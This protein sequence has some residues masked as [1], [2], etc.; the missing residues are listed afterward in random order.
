MRRGGNGETGAAGGTGG[1]A[2]CGSGTISLDGIWV[3]T[4][5][6]SIQAVLD[7][8]KE[9]CPDVTVKYNPAGD[10]IVTG[11]RDRGAGRQPA[12]PRDDRAAGDD[13]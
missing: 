10:N 9:K 2:D 1:G 7:G 13:P 5:Q 6:K 11:A 3:A 12:R 4:E 8:F